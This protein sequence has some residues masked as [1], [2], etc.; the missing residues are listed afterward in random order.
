MPTTPRTF[1]LKLKQQFPTQDFCPSAH[2][3]QQLRPG[4]GA[5]GSGSTGMLKCNSPTAFRMRAAFRN[6]SR[7]RILLQNHNSAEHPAHKR[8]CWSYTRGAWKQN[9]KTSPHCGARRPCRSGVASSPHKAV[10]CSALACLPCSSS[11]QRCSAELSR[12]RSC[13]PAALLLGCVHHSRA[14]REGL[15]QAIFSSNNKTGSRIS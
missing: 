11:V 14:Q 9:T 7:G 13:R 4:E 15:R 5:A 3:S 6:K 10:F 1:V 8:T 12:V 2:T